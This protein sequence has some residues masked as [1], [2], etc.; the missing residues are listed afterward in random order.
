MSNILLGYGRKSKAD[1]ANV[2]SL[3]RQQANVGKI[4]SVKGFELEWHQDHDLSGYF[5]DNRPEWQKVLSRLHDDD[6]IGVGCESL[7]RIYR[8]AGD[9]SQFKNRIEAAGKLLLIGDMPAVD[10]STATGNLT[11]GIHAMFAEFE[12][13]MAS[14]RQKKAAA[15]LKEKGRHL[16]TNPFG[17]DRDSQTKNLIPSARFY[18]Y[19]Q[20]TKQALPGPV[21]EETGE[22][23]GEPDP[24]PGFETRYYHDSLR[25]MY[26]LYAPGRMS[27]YEVAQV[28]NAN[29]WLFWGRSRNEPKN[30]NRLT[31]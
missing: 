5:E 28:L 14:E 26:E 31:A 15:R 13:R 27:Y 21:N 25:E 30:F 8:N 17:C 7:D 20:A 29:G 24:P 19:D 16:G 1:S 12:Y 23:E 10:G 4:A 6:T 2:P 11:L 9:F 18:Y 22:F 3:E